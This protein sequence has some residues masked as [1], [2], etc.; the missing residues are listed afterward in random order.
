VDGS[1]GRNAVEQ[2]AAWR[3]YVGITGLAI[4]KLDGTARGGFVV[5]VVRDLG[6]PIKLVGI[7]EKITDLRDF[8]AELF[9]DALLGNDMEK[10]EKLKARMNKMM[11]LNPSNEL[12]MKSY[13][14]REEYRSNDQSMDP[15]GRLKSAFGATD[16]EYN[17]I[18]NNKRK[19]KNKPPKVTNKKK[20]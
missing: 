1:L 11:S 10:S 8:Q 12:G 4:T 14:I 17:K 16:D 3:K 19:P 7:G 20:K 15:A 2:A 6:L 13:S 18:N 9:V 5:S